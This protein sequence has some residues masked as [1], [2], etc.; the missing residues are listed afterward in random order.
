[1]DVHVTDEFAPFDAAVASFLTP[2]PVRNT[3]LLTIL[4]TLRAGDGF[5]EAAP[6]FA[7][8][9][10]EGATVGA[11]LRTPPYKVALAGMS[12]DVTRALGVRLR[13]V[14]LPGAFGDLD[15]VAAFADAAGR[16]YRVHIHEIQHVLTKLVPP[17]QAP[18]AARPYVHQDGDLY[19]EWN[20][21]FVV[22]TG[23]TRGGLDV[24]AALERRIS[25]GGGLWLWEVDGVP[26]SMCGR[27]M[28]VC[29]VPRIGPVWTPPKHRNHG[30]AAAVTAYVCEQAF[31]DGAQACTLFADAANP[32]SNGIYE[33]IG[34]QPVAETVEAEFA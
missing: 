21:G 4:E 31:A 1:M 13:D 26:V 7:W 12:A 20:E 3:V 2:D 14:D 27:T 6:W 16:R 33:R 25:A 29:G 11:A 10:E 17:P 8:A 18:G 9:T 24:V 32:T 22:E 15:T 5:G 23:V 19:A 28:P 30:Y 34:F